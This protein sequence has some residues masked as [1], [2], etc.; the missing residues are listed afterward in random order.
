MAWKTDEGS[1]V[2]PGQWSCTQVCACNGCCA[3]FVALN[4][5]ITFHILLIWH[6]SHYFLFPK[7][8]KKYLAGKQYRT[9]DEV[10]SAV[11]NFF[12]D[13]DENFYTTG[14]QVLQHHWKNCEDHMGRLCWKNTNTYLVKF[15][16]CIIV[17]LWTDSPPSP[18]PRYKGKATRSKI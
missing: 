17:S 3:C 7:L 16:C 2:S 15:K 6:P 10:V 18:M 9:D 12:K 1:P 14:I 8:E 4:W 11:E 13:Q 5:V